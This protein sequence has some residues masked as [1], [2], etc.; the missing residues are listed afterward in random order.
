MNTAHKTHPL[1][2][3]FDF[4]NVPDVPDYDQILSDKANALID[5]L[6]EGLKPKEQYLPQYTFQEGNFVVLIASNKDKDILCNILDA[7]GNT[8]LGISA[9]WR[10]KNHIKN[11]LQ[12][13]KILNT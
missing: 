9:C 5:A 10:N 2:L 3:S 1:Q 13:L 7:Y 4:F 6:N 11:D 12:E 8:P